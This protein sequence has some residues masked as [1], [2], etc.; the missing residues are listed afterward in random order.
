MSASLGLLELALVQFSLAFL[1]VAGSVLDG[2][3]CVVGGAVASAPG[4]I[5]IVAVIVV[6]IERI[7]FVKV[8]ESHGLLVRF[9]YSQLV[10]TAIFV[11]KFR[12]HNLLF[13]L[14]DLLVD[15]VVCIHG[16]ALGRLGIEGSL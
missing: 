12:L 16:V 3:R 9:L 4:V 2:I 14:T 5:A 8:S 6:T 7:R 10:S 13:H 1:E 11:G 15:S